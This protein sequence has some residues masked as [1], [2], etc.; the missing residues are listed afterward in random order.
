MSR[1]GLGIGVTLVRGQGED[2]L[3]WDS[4]LDPI[5]DL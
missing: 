1:A 3:C 2:K 4:K 5:I